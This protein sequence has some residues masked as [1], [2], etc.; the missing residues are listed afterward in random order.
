MN[1]NT[2]VTVRVS[3]EP[4][5]ILH[6][7][8]Y[9][10]S[11]LLLEIFSMNHGLVALVARGARRKKNTS[12]YLFHPLRRLLLSWVI[13][14]DL[15]TLTAIEA[16]G[17][18]VVTRNARYLY[19]VLYI[20]ELILRLLRR[21]QPNSQLFHIYA[22][23][24]HTLQQVEETD[25]VLRYFEKNVLQHLGYGLLLDREA[26]VGAPVCAEMSY[27]YRICDDPGPVRKVH[28]NAVPISGKALLS[29]HQ[30][31]L[32][33]QSTATLEELKILMRM[34]IEQHLGGKQ[35]Q[36]RQLYRRF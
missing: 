31:T 13:R 9:H 30:E 22:E 26:D 2:P 11:S 24:L 20:N 36:C 25:I 3:L 15:G 33:Q 23:T 29:L 4:C 6:T 27:S 21:Y 12:R 34:V 16:D 18:A 1:I 5:Y 35:L 14:G 32:E 10:E 7:R 28:K 8:P 19:G 17:A